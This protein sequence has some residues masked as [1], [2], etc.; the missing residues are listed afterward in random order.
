[1]KSF[2]V[3]LLVIQKKAN[4]LFDTIVVK[5]LIKNKADEL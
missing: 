2:K 4:L 3:Q 5:K 1:M